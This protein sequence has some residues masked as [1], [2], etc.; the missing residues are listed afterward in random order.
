MSSPSSKTASGSPSFLWTFPEC[1]VRIHINFEF[2]E[3][4]QKEILA[5]APADREVGGLLIGNE[6]SPNGDIEVSDYIQLQLDSESTNNFVVCSDSLTRAKQNARAQGRVI[7]FYRTNLEDRIHFRAEDLECGQRMS[8]L[9][10]MGPFFQTHL[11]SL[12]GRLVLLHIGVLTRMLPV[13]TEGRTGRS[14]PYHSRSRIRVATEIPNE[15]NNT[16]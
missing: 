13:K 16:V 11:S 4:L 3:R 8:W 2:I 5:A 10:S 15:T 7:G 9:S 6:L 14:A 12:P 1:P